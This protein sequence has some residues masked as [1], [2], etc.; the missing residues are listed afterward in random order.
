MVEVI[1]LDPIGLATYANLRVLSERQRDDLRNLIGTGRQFHYIAKI[2]VDSTRPEGGGPNEIF[3]HRCWV[4]NA[5]PAFFNFPYRIKINDSVYIEI[6]DVTRYSYDNLGLD[7]NKRGKNHKNF[8]KSKKKRNRDSRG[9][10]IR[11]S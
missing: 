10:F 2:G 8:R 11:S 3:Y 9:R 4:E 6:N 1:G 5:E 7:G